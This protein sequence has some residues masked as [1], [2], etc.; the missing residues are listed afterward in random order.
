ML[1]RS[2][3][4]GKKTFLTATVDVQG[5]Q[6]MVREMTGLEREEFLKLLTADADLVIPEGAQAQVVRWCA[7]DEDLEPLFSEADDSKIA[8]MPGG[9]LEA[10]VLK[11]IDIS[12]LSTG[13]AENLEKNLE[14]PV[15]STGSGLQKLSA[16]Q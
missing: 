16:A 7:V 14:D 4:L 11:I 9:A 6:V 15:A 13:A 3:L 2:D 1:S 8:A 10:L 5:G 12:G